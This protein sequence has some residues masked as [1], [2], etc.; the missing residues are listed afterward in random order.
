MFKGIYSGI[1]S[2]C[3]KNKSIF[4]L[5]FI[6][7]IFLLIF[8]Y[9]YILVVDNDVYKV[10]FKQGTEGNVSAILENGDIVKQQIFINDSINGISVL[11]AAWGNEVTDG[12]IKIE[13]LDENQETHYESIWNATEIKDNQ[14]IEIEFDP[15]PLSSRGEIYTLCMTFDD[16]EDQTISFWMTDNH[17]YDDVDFILN[18]ESSAADMVISER[19]NS[20]Q[21][22]FLY[23]YI[24]VMALLFAIITASY[25]M[26]CKFK[27]K[28]QH[29]Y[30]FVAF[31][32]D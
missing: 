31:F 30:A 12:T 17:L 14:Y 16:I 5:L 29:I 20:H 7:I 28:I 2:I 11:F 22:R 23:A 19:I 1:Q 3:F 18:N 21:S 24:V 4:K 26:I 27:L 32:L 10:C 13:L 9:G 8:V 25:F 15:I 6:Q